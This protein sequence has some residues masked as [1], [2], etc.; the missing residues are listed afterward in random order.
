MCL[1]DL[2]TAVT[3]NL[4]RQDFKVTTILDI[5]KDKCSNYPCKVVE[6]PKQV[7]EEVD[8]TITGTIYIEISMTQFQF[9]GTERGVTIS[10]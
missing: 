9:I 3:K 8:I 7:A 2:G 4:L 10:F 5:N 1:F 6:T